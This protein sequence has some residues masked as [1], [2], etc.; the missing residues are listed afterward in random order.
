MVEPSFLAIYL[1]SDTVR[2][3]WGNLTLASLKCVLERHLGNI[4]LSQVKAKR[5][6]VY[7]NVQQEGTNLSRVCGGINTA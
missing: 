7:L 6:L 5:P 3:K 4:T 2:I 1:S